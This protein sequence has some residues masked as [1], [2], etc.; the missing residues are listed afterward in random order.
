M[1]GA[2]MLLAVVAPLGL[3]LWVL[4]VATAVTVVVI[5]IGVARHVAWFRAARRRER[6]RRE[7]QPVFA[8]FLGTYDPVH[9]GEELRPAFMRMD[10]AHRPVAAVLVTDLMRA[11]S[12][13]QAE[14]LR[15]ALEESGI[16]ELGERGTR[17]RSPWRRAL[18]CELLGAVGA[19]RSV[20]ALLERLEDKRPE[21]RTAAVR[22]LADIGSADALPALSEAPG[23]SSTRARL[24]R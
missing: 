15:A 16:V 13:A 23:R 11:A 6:V 17:R 19:Q 10:A 9:L 21:V 2:S 1:S 4:A 18:A 7:C 14:Q 22:A 5:A 3:T 24:P 20:P 12:P 8:R